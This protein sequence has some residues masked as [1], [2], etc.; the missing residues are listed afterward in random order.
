MEK[1]PFSESELEV[2]KEIP[3]LFGFGVSRIYNRPITEN[4]NMRLLYEEDHPMWIPAGR[5]ANASFS[6]AVIPDNIARAFVF[7]GTGFDNKQ[8][9]GPDMFGI[10]WVYVPVVGGSMEDPDVPHLFEDAND[11]EKALTFPDIDSWDWAG[12]RKANEEYLKKNSDKWIASYLLNGAWF[13]RLISFMGFENAALALIDEDQED[14]LKAL[15]ART[16]KLYMDIV[17]KYAEFFPEVDALNIHDDWGSQKA[18]FFSQNTAMEM[19]VPFMKQLTDHIK[20]KGFI[21]DMHSCGHNFSRIEA[22]IAGGWESW[23]PQP[24]NDTEKLFEEY[25]DK[26]IITVDLKLPLDMTDEQQRDCAKKFVE[27][28]C[29]PGKKLKVT[30]DTHLAAFEKELYKQSRL[31]YLSF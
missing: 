1:I 6:P 16:T 31:A 25:G 3:G 11:W 8:G 13:E 17:D 23:T 30:V 24:M 4:E 5:A 9:G 2:V 29:I 27:T 22:Y 14:A 15:F 7:D 18:P 28:H 21:A 20:S 19:I 12:C 10:P 26:I